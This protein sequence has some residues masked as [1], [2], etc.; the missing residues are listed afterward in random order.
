MELRQLTYL[1]AV[2][3]HGTFTAA[4]R[5][6]H[7]A[8]PSLSQAV[9]ALEGELGVELFRRTGRAVVLTSAGHAVVAHPREVLPAGAAA[10]SAAG[11][12]RG[13]LAGQLQ[14]SSLPPLAVD[15]LTE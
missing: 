8:Q 9:R 1:V 10:R 12:A 14:S 3:D 4:A 5:A 13:L 2:A 11:A 15:P 7:V 6:S